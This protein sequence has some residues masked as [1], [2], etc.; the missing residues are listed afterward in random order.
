MTTA[1]V[2][3]SNPKY[4]DLRTP[5]PAKDGKVDGAVV[6]KDDWAPLTSI[7]ACPTLTK[8]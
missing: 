2:G 1:N 5:A 4:F 3:N 8:T 6:N 7:S